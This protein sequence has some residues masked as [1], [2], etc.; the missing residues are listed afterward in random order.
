MYKIISFGICPFVQRS[1]ITLNYKK[2]PYEVKYIDLANKPDWFLKISPTGKVPVLETENGVIFESA[3]IN[4]YIDEVSDG[5]LLPSDPYKRAQERAYIELSSAVIWSYFNTAVA[6]N[7]EGYLKCKVELENN[8][9]SLLS[10]FSGPFFRGEELSLVDTA[11]IPSLQR[12]LLTK[13][14][15]EDLNLSQENKGKF[16]KWSQSAASLKEVEN[17][18]P[19]SFVEDYKA[20]L[21]KRNSYIHMRNN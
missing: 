19:F 21:V 1:I 15:F 6:Q 18:V 14:L 10:K 9:T 12:I 7:E 4:E 8:L 13:N 17:S 11:A 16:Q 3:V 5:S 2:V 20:Y